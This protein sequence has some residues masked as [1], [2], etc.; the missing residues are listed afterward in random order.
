MWGEGG[1]QAYVGTMLHYAEPAQTLTRTYLGDENPGPA[2]PKLEKM[3]RDA[4][5]LPVGGPE[6][7]KAYQRIGAYLAEN[8]IHVPIVQYSTVVLARPEAV[9]SENIV[10]QDIGKADFRRV[11]VTKR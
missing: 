9:G 7:E 3:A 6:R 1:S 8:P 10:V 11:G 2:D 4:R 5:A